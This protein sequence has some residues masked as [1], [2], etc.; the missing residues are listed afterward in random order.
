MSATMKCPKCKTLTT[1]E[2]AGKVG[3]SG[4]VGGPLG[5]PTVERYHLECK[6]PNCGHVWYPDASAVDSK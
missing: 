6:R 3:F 5:V 1:G 4:S 2:L